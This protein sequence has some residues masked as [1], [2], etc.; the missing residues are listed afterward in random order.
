MNSLDLHFQYRHR[1]CSTL[2]KLLLELELRMGP[3]SQNAVRRL[4]GI[5][6]QA[7]EACS[8]VKGLYYYAVLL[9]LVS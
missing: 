7:S 9:G 8:W 3:Q 4:H 1:I 2:W 5:V 6:Y